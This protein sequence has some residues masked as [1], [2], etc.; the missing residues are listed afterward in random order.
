MRVLIES[1]EY[2]PA[3]AYE[4]LSIGCHG[5]IKSPPQSGTLRRAIQTVAAGERFYL[6][7]HIQSAA[8]IRAGVAPELALTTRD[9]A[10]ICLLREK[11]NYRQI[12]TRLGSTET[13]IKNA[14]QRLKYKLQNYSL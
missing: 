7:E 11:R 1:K 2:T 13:D 5:L 14:C 8:L 4:C 6:D 10:I 9:C 12:A 3:I